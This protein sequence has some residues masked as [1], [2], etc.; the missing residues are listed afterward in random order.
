MD[1]ENVHGREDV[2][3]M[4][5]SRSIET[6]FSEIK[7]YLTK[8]MLVLDV[9]CG[10]GTITLGVANEVVPG[11]VVGVD[12]EP[13]SIEQAVVL[14]EE[15]GVENVEFKVGDAYSLE[16]PDNTFDLTYSRVVVDWLRDP[17]AALKEQRRVTKPRA[18]VLMQ[19][20]LG[21]GGVMYP[22]Y[23]CLRRL[24]ESMRLLQD[25]S[26]D[27]FY[28]NPLGKRSVEML[29]K[30]GFME[31]SIQPSNPRCTYAGSGNL[32]DSSI[33]LTTKKI[34]D[35]LERIPELKS[36]LV[37]V[38]ALDD[39][40]IEQARVELEKWTEHPHAFAFGTSVLSV[41]QVP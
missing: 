34:F 5:A 1:N 31:I 20:G 26:Q 23:P 8:G 24:M 35:G 14:T 13:K 7:P 9:G 21:G 37:A 25:P 6:H 27:D 30:A 17:L 19:T 18:W 29:S 11:R 33:N 22:E 15:Q 38:G 12:S 10:P 3:D 28:W 39:W 41:G 36:R 32:K 40:T 2:R 4:Y 16:F